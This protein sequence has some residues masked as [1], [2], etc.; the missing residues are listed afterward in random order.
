MI[1][2]GSKL[3]VGSAGLAW[4]AAAVYG[5]A[6]E[7]I[8]GTIGLISLA[9]ALS[10]LA[11]INL[12]IGDANVS[13]MDH[14][15]FESSAAAQATARPSLWP[16][17][18]GLGATAVT[19]GLATFPVIFVIGIVLIFAGTVEWLIQ[20]WAE[21]AS[22]DRRYN[23]QVR[24]LMI[25]PLELPV[26]GAILFAGIVYGFSR[27]MLGVPSK[28]TTVVVFS[29]IAVVLL[30]VGAF[31][32]LDRG[33]SKQLLGGVYGVGVLALIVGGSVYGLN[34]EREIE[35]HET[36]ADLAEEDECGTEKTHADKKGSQT[37]ASKSNP[38]AVITFTGSALEVDVPG[39]DGDYQLTLPRSNPHNILFR[40]DSDDYARLVLEMH[41]PVDDDGHP[42][43]TERY[44]TTLLEE[45]GVQF[46][47]VEFDRPSFALEAE[48]NSYEFLVPG[49]DA[50][51]EVVVP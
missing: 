48:G 37:V 2:T 47:T 45:T 9:V 16:L 11:G 14:E 17:L 51:V 43:A 12:F 6:Q 15:A 19:L 27:V 40:N 8:L 4:V 30:A 13:A 24:D 39:F 49:S 20:G 21:R 46:L 10:L 26:A 7:G 32:A 23:A 3:L 18:V 42:L 29:V 41:P 25:D 34:G 36:P 22:A 28:T 35:V 44:C 38:S 1:T 33:I 50:T 5:I 31:I